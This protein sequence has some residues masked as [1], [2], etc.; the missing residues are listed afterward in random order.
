MWHSYSEC[1]I[2]PI[3]SNVSEKEVCVM[4]KQVYEIPYMCGV[5]GNSMT[6]KEYKDDNN[7]LMECND[8]ECDHT[9][10]ATLE[11]FKESEYWCEFTAYGDVNPIE[12]GGQWVKKVSENDYEAITLDY[13]EGNEVLR[14]GTVLLDISDAWIDKKS[15]LSYAD[16]SLDYPERFVLDAISYYGIVNCGGSI[17]TYEL[18]N[19]P[20]LKLDLKERYNICL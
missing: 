3:G 16:G 5:C 8:E 4:N 2:E 20:Q 15:V 7:I 10:W 1:P 17:D 11:A 19:I 6:V 13:D 14:L 18:G 12:H 9:E